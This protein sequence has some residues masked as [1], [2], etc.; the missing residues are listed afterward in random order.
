MG[1]KR[2][3]RCFQLEP[4]VSELATLH[5]GVA[6]YDQRRCGG[7]GHPEEHNLRPRPR[8]VREGGGAQV[9]QLTQVDCVC[10][11]YPGVL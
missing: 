2:M 4:F 8:E 6:L 5:R 10:V 3:R 9:E 11:V 7:D 1:E